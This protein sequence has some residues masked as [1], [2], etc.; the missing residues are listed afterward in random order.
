MVNNFLQTATFNPLWLT[1]YLGFEILPKSPSVQ[2]SIGKDVGYWI[3]LDDSDA[4]HPG[5]E[6]VFYSPSFIRDRISKLPPGR[7]HFQTNQT[8][9]G[10][11]RL[12]YYL[13]GSLIDYCLNFALPQYIKNT[14]VEVIRW[15]EVA[16]GQLDIPIP[17]DLGSSQ[18]KKASIFN[19][20]T[21]NSQMGDID[22]LAKR[23]VFMSPLEYGDARLI[24]S[25]EPEIISAVD[26][27]TY[28]ISSLPSVGIVPIS[29]G[30]KKYDLTG[31]REFIETAEGVTSESISTW[32]QNHLVE[33]V[34]FSSSLEESRVIAQNLMNKFTS[35]GGIHLIPFDSWIYLKVNSEIEVEKKYSNIKGS[36][37]TCKFEL[38]ITNLLD[39]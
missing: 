35:H 1:G 25:Y 13:S 15:V 37:R 16:D 6:P 24:I 10:E 7:I 21:G 33:V 23:I 18:V 4:W 20:T 28:Q 12:G 8:Y 34:A 14:G 38:L 36:V 9:S 5:D 3:W 31:Y 22:Y 26:Q 11:I 27:Q 32:Q 2:I 19:F 29:P 30:S 17:A 39:G